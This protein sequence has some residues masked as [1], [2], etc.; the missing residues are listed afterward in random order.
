MKNI[1]RIALPPLADLTA[2]TLL[3][4]AWFDRKGQ[5]ARHGA[6]A[7]GGLA[8][9]FP[10]VPVQ[11]VLHPHDAI[12]ASVQ[13][14]AVPAA[15]FGA[16]VHA[17]LEALVLSDLGTLAVGHGARAADGS[18][19]VAWAD[20]A[21]LQ[22]AWKLLSDAGLPVRALVP[23]Q[24]LPGA[25]GGQ[26]D[27]PLDGPDDPRWRAEAPGWSLALPRLAPR[28][29]S[30]WA[31][32]LRWAALAAV[33]WIAGLNLYAMQ[34]RA[35]TDGLRTGMVDQVRDAFPGIPVVL[36]AVRQAQQG[37]DALL[38]GNGSSGAGDFLALARAAAQ[39]LP[40][41]SDRV[42]RLQYGDQALTLQLA[43]QDGD[44]D[45]LGDAP[46]IVQKAATLG[47]RVERDDNPA[48]WRIVP[49]QP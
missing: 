9:A 28:Q 49:A 2:A 30:R 1:L 14:P 40:F 42:D 27:R 44:T 21:A 38:A 6:L 33:L 11:A 19:E 15:R 8:G 10:R 45:R 32:A 20:S 22:R 48:N 29:P 18:V 26:A 35:E 43:P 3:D 12:A 5:R 7:A 37:Y 24:A 23:L 16:A 31:P 25:A 41:A 13:V 39:V 46:A 34:L 17:A 47:V 4:Y 36:D